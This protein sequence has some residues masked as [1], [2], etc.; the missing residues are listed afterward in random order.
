MVKTLRESL[1]DY[2]MAMLRALAEVRGAVLT[3]NHRVTAANELAAQVST[4]ASLAIAL[5][6]LSPAETEALAEVQGAG[7]WMEAPRFA[8][9]F[10]DV[11]TMGPGR[12]ERE[13]PWMAPAN[14]AEGLW[15]RALFF[16][17]FRQR[18]EG[19]VEI[20]YIPGDLL[21]LLSDLSAGRL[22]SRND[23]IGLSIE[24]TT[25]PSHI[26][27]ADA[28]M[29]EDVFGIMVAARNQTI[30]LKTDGSLYP[31]EWQA[32][33]VLCVSPLPAAS[34]A[35]DERLVFIVHISC[36][37]KLVTAAEGRLA[38]NSDPARA[39]LQ[40]SPAQRLLALQTTWRDDPNWNDLWRVPTLRPQATGWKNDPAL[41]RGKALSVL[42]DCRPGDWYRLDELTQAVKASDPDFQRPDGDY[43]TWY[44]QDL[45]GLP[46]MGF[47]HWEKVEGA[48]LRYLVSGPLHWLGVTDLGLEADSD[49]PTALRLA[50]A[51][52]PLLGLA[53]LPEAESPGTASPYIEVSENFTVRV[54]LAAS[55]YSRF[56]LARFTDLSGRGT[57]HV[58]YRISPASLTRA[59]Q[60]GIT[61]D[62]ISTFLNRASGDRVPARVLEGL[63]IW[64][65]RSGS[66]RLEQRVVLR[67]NRPETLKALRQDPDIAPLLGE[68]L[69]PQAVLV[70]RPNMKQVRRWLAEQGYLDIKAEK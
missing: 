41:A 8:R 29:V 24:P 56:Q 12:L 19:M 38:L 20:V 50:D 45:N 6:D 61:I 11:R 43:T 31:K 51:G 10:G 35:D 23:N 5:A 42:A 47:E 32:I 55:L 7:G 28:S 15:Y 13:Q 30:R 22:P 67:V 59:R 54:P 46:L 37:A 63:R 58:R 21:T 68:V 69:G 9:R 1:V 66:A 34:V 3:S 39:W 57:D 18:E 16:K 60:G 33:N 26:Q 62:Q 52:L 27:P 14:P 70:P 49:Q 40:A 44:I 53:P 65:E 36:A 2:D 48:L 64:Q 25:A 17:G 4:P